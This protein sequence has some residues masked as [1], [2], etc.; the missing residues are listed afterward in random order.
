MFAACAFWMMKITT[1][2][3]AATPAMSPVRI[4]LI[5]VCSRGRGAGDGGGGGGADPLAEGGGRVLVVPCGAV[6]WDM[7]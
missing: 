7:V 4:P 5:R 6:G 3:R 2:M 1:T